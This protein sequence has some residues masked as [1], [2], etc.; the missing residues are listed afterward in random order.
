MLRIVPLP[1]GER[2][3]LLHVGQQRLNTSAPCVSHFSGEHGIRMLIVTPVVR[4]QDDPLFF[5][6]REASCDSRLTTREDYAIGLTAGCEARTQR[7][8]H[9]A[10][11]NPLGALRTG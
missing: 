3:H 9:G 10:D 5:A 11:V 7:A 6:V 1:K 2:A 8:Q 4:H